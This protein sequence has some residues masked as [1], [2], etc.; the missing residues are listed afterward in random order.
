MKWYYISVSWATFGIATKDGIVKITAP[1]GKWM[2]GKTFIF[3]KQWVTNKKGI[4][5]KLK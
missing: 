3:I 1:I 5:I 2:L 4:I